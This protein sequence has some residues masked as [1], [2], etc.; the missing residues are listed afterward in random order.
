MS[1]WIQFKAAIMPGE[2]ASLVPRCK[3]TELRFTLRRTVIND[4]DN[5]SQLV[6]RRDIN[7]EQ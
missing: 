1:R 4:A 6:Y 2:S 3:H 5:S 7:Q